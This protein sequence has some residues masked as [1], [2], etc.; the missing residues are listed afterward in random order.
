LEY[1]KDYDK[2]IDILQ[3]DYDWLH[4]Y[5]Y[6]ILYIDENLD[7]Y[8]SITV[9]LIHYSDFLDENKKEKIKI[10]EKCGNI[11]DVLNGWKVIF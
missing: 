11:P 10:T 4:Y 6:I 1:T 7:L 3:I 8:D 5:I 2:K 9:K